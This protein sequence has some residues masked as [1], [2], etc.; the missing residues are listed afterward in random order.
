M[1]ARLASL[2]GGG[3]DGGATGAEDRKA[4]L[5]MFLEKRPDKGEF[6]LKERERARERERER[7]HPTKSFASPGHALT[8]FPFGS[9]N[10]KT[11]GSE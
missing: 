11:S 8:H 3:G 1:A 5:E 4:W 6:T 7:K 10:M 2:C 9:E